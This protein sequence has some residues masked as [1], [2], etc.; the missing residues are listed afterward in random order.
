MRSE[1]K[2]KEETAKESNLLLSNITSAS[3][4]A[5]FQDM[6]RMLLSLS[7]NSWDYEEK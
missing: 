4:C 1:L 5:S 3:T 2:R 7:P 6:H